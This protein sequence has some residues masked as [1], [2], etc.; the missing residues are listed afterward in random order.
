[1]PHCSMSGSNCYRTTSEALQN[2]TFECPSKCQFIKYEANIQMEK[3]ITEIL[4]ELENFGVEFK[5]ALLDD[6]SII[7]VQNMF[8]NLKYGTVKQKMYLQE[9]VKSYTLVQVYFEDPQVTII[10]KDAKVT[11]PDQ[12]SNTPFIAYKSHIRKCQVGRPTILK[13]THP[14]LS[15]GG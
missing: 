1:M 10:T 2:G 3:P 4:P 12:V 13:S 6:P 8:N 5:K 7:F 14:G 11:I 15:T 9:A